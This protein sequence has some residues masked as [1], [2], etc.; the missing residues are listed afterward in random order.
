MGDDVSEQPGWTVKFTV[1][2][3]TIGGR[4][5]G[6]IN[7]QDD[8]KTPLTSLEDCQLHICLLMIQFL[9]SG[10]LIS[11][12]VALSPQG[13]ETPNVHHSIPQPIRKRAVE[14]WQEKQHG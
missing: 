5:F 10:N 1:T 14:L 4:D 12:S 11:C 3:G 8:R 13:E 6:M 9:R 7:T 2:N